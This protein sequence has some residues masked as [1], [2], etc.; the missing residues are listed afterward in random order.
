MSI[1]RQYVSQRSSSG[2]KPFSPPIVRGFSCVPGHVESISSFYPKYLWEIMSKHARLARQWIELSAMCAR[3]R[4]E[5]KVA[6]YTDLAM[7]PVTDDETETLA[8][9]THNDGARSQVAH[10]RKVDALTHGKQAAVGP[11]P[12]DCR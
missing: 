7:T 10:V 4:R 11:A 3:A 6:P 5:Q 12:H 8:M 1:T 2:E 9:F